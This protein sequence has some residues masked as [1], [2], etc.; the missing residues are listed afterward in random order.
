MDDLG[1][2]SVAGSRLS[3]PEEDGA[4]RGIGSA[5]LNP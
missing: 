1:D 3:G 4:Q 5:E 2:D